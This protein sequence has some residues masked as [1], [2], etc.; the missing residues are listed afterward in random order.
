M[1]TIRV[2]EQD[3]QMLRELVER[4][5]VNLHT[6]IVHTDSSEYRQFLKE[7]KRALTDLLHT[8]QAQISPTPR[9]QYPEETIPVPH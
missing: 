6:E 3:Q 1:D 4:E 5:V 2:S 9:S 7:R 8:L